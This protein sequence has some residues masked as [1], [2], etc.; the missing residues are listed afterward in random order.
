GADDSA[1]TP[2]R[3]QQAMADSHYY[4]QYWLYVLALHRHL[5]TVK[6]DYDYERDMGGVR[7]LFLRGIAAATRGVYAAR[8]S[9]ALVEALD[10]LMGKAG[11]TA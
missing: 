2:A 11:V 9:L 5:K 8:P 1:Y 7:Y 4:L 6:K 10:A 3:L